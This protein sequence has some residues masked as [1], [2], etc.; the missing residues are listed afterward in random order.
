METYFSFLSRSNYS[1]DKMEQQNIKIFDLVGI[2]IIITFL[3][4]F[5]D[6]ETIISVYQIQVFK[7]VV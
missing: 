7:T 1:K 4:Y 2:S 6:V 3:T 5:H